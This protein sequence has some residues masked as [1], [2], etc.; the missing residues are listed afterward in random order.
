MSLNKYQIPV[1]I[2]LRGLSA[3]A[4]CFYHF[5]CT[6]IGFIDNERVLSVFHY[7]KFGVNL[8]FIISGVVIPI[9]MIS[10]DYKLSRWISFLGKRIIRIEPPYIAAILI[11]IIYLYARNFIPGSNPADLTPSVINVILHLGYLI[12]FFENQTWINP[13]FWTLAIE[14]QYYLVM[15]LLF[16]LALHKKLMLRI[17]FYMIFIIPVFFKTPSDLFPYWSIYFLFGILYALFFTQKIGLS[18]YL[19]ASITTLILISI[20]MGTLNAGIAFSGIAIIHFFR[21]FSWKPGNFIG[22]ISYSLYLLHSI[23]GAAFVNFFSHRAES[24]VEKI[25]VIIS[26]YLISVLAAYA[27]YRIIERPS[28]QLSRKL[29][30]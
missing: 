24:S 8:F 20:Y 21:N 19:I 29:F 18:E 11:G 17:L 25:L 7:G 27:M 28:Q 14:F 1:I 5:I 23:I 10:G 2:S 9:S 4:V 16:P 13:V 22:N 26:G 3:T 12:P 6:T 15:S 30:N